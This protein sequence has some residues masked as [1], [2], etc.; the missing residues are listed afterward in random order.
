MKLMRSLCLVVYILAVLAFSAVPALRTRPLLFW[1][2]LL[3]ITTLSI[4][5]SLFA[6]RPLATWPGLLAAAGCTLLALVYLAQPQIADPSPIR[7]ACRVVISLLAWSSWIATAIAGV[8]LLIRKDASVPF[9]AIAWT[10]FPLLLIGLSWRYGQI[11]RFLGAPLEEQLVWMTP[12][13]WMVGAFCLGPIAFLSHLLIL[14]KKELIEEL[15]AVRTS[16][17]Q[18]VRPRDRLT[19]E[20]AKSSV[21]S[22][23]GRQ[24]REDE[25]A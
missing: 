13:L 20:G 10:C 1:G 25:N 23:G 19:A 3:L 21:T 24:K 11:D 9:L 6:H 22:M 14:L 12:L 8:V 4:C 15:A 18:P 7:Q 2:G 17:S 16:P 5:L